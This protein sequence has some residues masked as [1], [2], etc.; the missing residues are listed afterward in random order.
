MSARKLLLP[1][2]VSLM[3]CPCWSATLLVG[4][5][6]ETPYS[7]ISTALAASTDGDTILVSA[8]IYA[9]TTGETFPLQMKSGVSLIHRVTNSRP[10]IHASG[11]VSALVFNGVSRVL[12]QG[13]LITGGETGTKGAGLLFSSANGFIRDCVISDN[14]ARRSGGGV[15]CTSGSS[16]EFENCLF[17]NNTGDSF[18]GG[19]HC[20]NG[21]SP[22]FKNCTFLANTGGGISCQQGGSPKFVGCRILGNEGIIGA[23][24][25][26]SS[27]SPFFQDCLFTG[28]K[29]D[30]HINPVGGGLFCTDSMV[31]LRHCV[32]SGNTAKGSGG[33][34]VADQSTVSLGGCAV[35]GNSTKGKG[36]GV[37]FSTLSKVSMNSCI[38]AGN[39]ADEGGGIF[40][41]I[42]EL[43]ASGCIIQ[44]N[45][46]PVGAWLSTGN[47][48]P[49]GLI[50]E[51]T[52]ANSIILNGTADVRNDDHS[53]ISIR[54]SIVDESIPGA[55]NLDTDP[56]F[57][58]GANGTWKGVTYPSVAPYQTVLTTASP[59][60]WAPDQFADGSMFLLP[61][62]SLT[63]L[64]PIVSNTTQTLTV[65]GDASSVAHIGG[66]FQILGF[67][68]SLGSPC[69]DSGS[70]VLHG[71]AG[72]MVWSFGDYAGRVR[73][74]DGNGDGQPVIDMGAFEYGYPP[75]AGDINGDGDIN[76]L[77]F[78]Q[79]L[80]YWRSVLQP[81]PV[82]GDQ[83]GDLV[84]DTNDLL[85]LLRD[86]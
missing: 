64:F 7:S 29:A 5:Q 78:I 9:V 32:I 26:C 31:S 33:G 62:T 8:G 74:A 12:V 40:S 63:T 69:I 15:L 39:S 13:F 21:S 18:G 38:L 76:R 56:L 66:A 53:P 23:G 50:S 34:V 71:T 3:V 44:G 65:W 55:G 68:L 80:L 52:M 67:R 60:S 72:N 10:R 79:L 73:A 2:L 42:S 48:L 41:S 11:G 54:H 45:T 14:Y 28:N 35:V 57:V 61:D 24:V 84:F 81:S 46:A 22:L 6:G 85:C 83:N 77:D 16:P 17:E 19:A 49:S 43:Q 59:S 4:H 25:Y 36:G 51:V 30:T 82:P 86:W 20:E 70:N 1:L 75:L 58:S 47:L 37:L 27:A